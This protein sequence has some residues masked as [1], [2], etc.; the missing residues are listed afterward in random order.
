VTDASDRRITE[1]R[2]ARTADIDLADALAVV[3][4]LNAEDQL[5]APAVGAARESIAAVVRAAE[6]TL[7]GGGRMYYFGAGTS[8]RLGVLDASEIPPTFGADP[9]LVQGVI[10]GGPA[11]L[12][13]AQEGAE[14]DLDDAAVQ[15]DARAIGGGDLVV[16]IAASGTTPWVRAALAHAQL[17]GARTAL[18][19]CSPPPPEMRAVADL[20]IVVVVGPEAVTGSTRLKAGTATKL[21]LNTITTA[22][23]VR[24][25]KVWG[26]L[27]VDLRATNAKLR[28]RS[29]RMVCEVTGLGHDDARS[30][31]LA[32]DG[33]VKVALVMHLLAVDAATAAARL[34][35]AGGVVR[36]VLPH[37]PPPIP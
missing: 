8:G 14:D 17:R 34:A 28:D 19:A 37:S 18:I 24:L 16:G 10:A 12:L 4:L 5:V 7:R 25:G 3:D 33:Q 23:M 21:V 27:M 13:Q 20:L 35:D 15:V 9:T 30:L 1:Q 32:A 22:A 6:E 2:N 29:V 36:R 26:N 31:L 11:A